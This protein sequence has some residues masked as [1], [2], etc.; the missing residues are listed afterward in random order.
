[1]DSSGQAPYTSLPPAQMTQRP[2]SNGFFSFLKGFLF[3][4]LGLIIGAGGIGLFVLYG[5]GGDR[6]PLPTP[7]YSGNNAIIAEASKAY[8]T[9]LV[10]L[11][12]STSN[13]PGKLGNIQVELVHNGPITVKADNQMTILG[14]GVTRR[15]TLVMQ[16]LVNSCQLSVRVLHA[17]MEGIPITTFAST[18]ESEINQELQV[19]PT[20]L[21]KGFT[22]CLTGVRTEPEG[23]FV[24]YSAVPKS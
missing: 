7:A 18:F 20:G 3:F 8:V 12:A 16:P 17:D 5:G 24:T 15:F 2:R 13:L 23:L 1:M 6:A 11:H 21:P 9:Q 14:I 4:V 22:Y 19:A 10:K